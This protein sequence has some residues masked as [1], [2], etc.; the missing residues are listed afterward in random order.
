MPASRWRPSA[1]ICAG[2]SRCARTAGACRRE[3]LP[4][5]IEWAA[6]GPHPA[7]RL[8]ASGVS[9]Q[10]FEAR[11]GLNAWLDTPRGEVQLSLLA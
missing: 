2:A 8:P 4:T 3:G 7:D 1:A 5:L 11:D 9:L 6:G 10:R